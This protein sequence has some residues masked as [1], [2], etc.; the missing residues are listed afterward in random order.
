MN[1]SV[2]LTD[3]ELEEVCSFVILM[4]RPAAGYRSLYRL[5]TQ[6][7]FKVKSRT[8]V[9]R[10]VLGTNVPLLYGPTHDEATTRGSHGRYVFRLR[11]S[12]TLSREARYI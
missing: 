8:G 11:F 5:A 10:P 2:K 9:E 12:G 7:T 3:C 1:Q 6:P 4:C